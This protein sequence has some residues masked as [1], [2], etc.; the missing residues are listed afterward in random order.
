MTCRGSEC[1]GHDQIFLNDHHLIGFLWQLQ[2][3]LGELSRC[4]D[5]FLEEAS[6]Y[7]EVRNYLLLLHFAAGKTHGGDGCCLH[8]KKR[9]GVILK[10]ADFGAPCLRV[11][12]SNL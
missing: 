1:D 11:T 5:K 2:N 3:L 4:A 6:K 9:G 10:H 7:G 12:L 8:S